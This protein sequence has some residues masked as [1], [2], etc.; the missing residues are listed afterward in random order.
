MKRLVI[1]TSRS[2]P[3]CR[4]YVRRATE[5]LPAT[6]FD[7]SEIKAVKRK[8]TGVPYTFVYDDETVLKEWQGANIEPLFECMEEKN[9][10]VKFLVDT[11][12]K[13]NRT[14]YK[15]NTVREFPAE[16]AEELI[17]AGVAKEQVKKSDS[18]NNR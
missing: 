5:Y 16:R 3:H 15:R 6:V 13:Y 8:I 14:Y 10:K 17:K 7:L 18:N 2:C 9:M 4:N 1:I 11:V 12:D